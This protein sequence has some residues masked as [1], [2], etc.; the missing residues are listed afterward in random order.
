MLSR[1]PFDVVGVT[2]HLNEVYTL[3]EI[4]VLRTGALALLTIFIY[5]QVRK[6]WRER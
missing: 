6:H 2:S 3:I 4:V 1:L 5:K